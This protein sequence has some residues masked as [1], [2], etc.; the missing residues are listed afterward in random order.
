M[1]KKE[2]KIQMTELFM[3]KPGNDF[4]RTFHGTI[5]REQDDDGNP[6]VR[7]IIKVN[8]G[9]ILA[10]AEDQWKLGTKLDELVLM[11]LDKDLHKNAG[12]TS[13]IAEIPF[14]IN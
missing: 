9:Y 5:K 1:K 6:V 10:Q 8:N 13:I 3:A 7:S 11:N 12:K 2:S 4:S 14:F